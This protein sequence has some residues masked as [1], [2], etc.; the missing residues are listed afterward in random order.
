[1]AEPDVPLYSTMHLFKYLRI[2]LLILAAIGLIVFRFH[3]QTG[4]STPEPGAILRATHTLTGN[5]KIHQNFHSSFLPTDRTLTVYLPPGYEA[6]PSRRYPVLYMQDGQNLFDGATSFMPGKEWQMDEKAELLI[7]QG[8]IE[9]LI[10]VGISSTG[11]ARINDFTPPM[12]GGPKPG[13]HADLYGRM[14]VEEIKPFIDGQYRTKQRAADTGLGGMSLGGLVT[15]YLGFKYPSVFGKLAI[16]S[17]AAFWNDQR[18][19]GYTRSLPAKTKQRIYLSVGAAEA[20]EFLDSTRA[21]ERALV[22]K[23]W[24]LGVDFDYF[25]APGAE[26]PPGQRAARVEQLLRFL[27]PTT[28]KRETTNVIA[29]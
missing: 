29:R 7:E 22:D 25:E 6:D 16:T 27:S 17:P 14:L 18:I 2:S 12:S 15:V 8:D 19:V 26:H 13:G 4:A 20:P 28:P 23:G 9:P 3:G 21:L 24:R 10:I 11:L 1:M 5:I